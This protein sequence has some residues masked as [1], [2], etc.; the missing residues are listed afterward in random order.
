MPVPRTDIVIAV[1]AT[2]QYPMEQYFV[3]CIESLKQTVSDYRVIL[4]NDSSDEV[5]TKVI[6]S[7]FQ[8]LPK[9]SVLINTKE[10]NWFTRAY[11]KGLRMVKT[12]YAVALNAD[13]VLRPGWLEELY[14]VWREAS[15]NGI[16]VGLVGSV[17]SEIEPY[18][19]KPVVQPD[20]VTGHCW[21]LSMS[22][23]LDASADRGTPGWYLDETTQRNI[24]I[25]SDNEIC[26]RLQKLGY[27]TI[28]SYKSGVGH[29][30]GKS[31]GH[32]LSSIWPLRLE[33]LPD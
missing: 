27:A 10:Q 32:D 26:Y 28:V 2:R 22:A 29:H 7:V 4:A 3:P 8:T 12:P 13:T 18:R 19:W 21:L 24:H 25:F 17:E 9:G 6:E 16:N 15:T 23:L 33:D 5:G 31:W 20:Y 14:D 1:R 11:N 30:G